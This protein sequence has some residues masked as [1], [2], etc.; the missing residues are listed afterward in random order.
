M[1]QVPVRVFFALV[2]VREDADGGV[3][4]SGEAAEEGKGEAGDGGE[5]AVT[6]RRRRGASRRTRWRPS[7]IRRTRRSYILMF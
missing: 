2:A 6:A 5:G 1:Q 7:L 4:L 3:T